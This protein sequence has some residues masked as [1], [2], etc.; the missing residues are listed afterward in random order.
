VRIT[1]GSFYE[2]A[3]GWIRQGSDESIIIRIDPIKTEESPHGNS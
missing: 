1:K 2:C 3:G